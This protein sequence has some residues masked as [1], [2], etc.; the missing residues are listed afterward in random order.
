MSVRNLVLHNPFEAISIF[1][2]HDNIHIVLHAT[3]VRNKRKTFN[4]ES[5]N[6]F[7]RVYNTMSLK[8]DGLLIMYWGVCKIPN[9]CRDE[10]CTVFRCVIIVILFH[11]L[12]WRT[13]LNRYLLLGQFGKHQVF[14]SHRVFG[15]NVISKRTNV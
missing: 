12:S 13:T 3:I 11:T 9:M 15:G 7:K 1:F 8:V 2:W 10:N 14:V 4:C 6:N 5:Q